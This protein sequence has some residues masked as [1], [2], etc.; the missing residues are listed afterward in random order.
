MTE[1][2]SVSPE[3]C[4]LHREVIEAKLLVCNERVDWILEELKGVRDLQKQ[5]LY[6]LIFLSVGV[7]LT[8]FGVL[9]GR[10]VDFGWLVP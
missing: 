4:S 10:G 1:T 3:M 2:T 9:I 8:L 5:I 6:T 7:S